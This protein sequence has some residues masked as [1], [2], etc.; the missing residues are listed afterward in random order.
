MVAAAW[1]RQ[2]MP[3]YGQRHKGL[4]RTS[5]AVASNDARW[6]RWVGA[7]SRPKGAS[8]LRLRHTIAGRRCTSHRSKGALAG[9]QAR[10]ESQHR[11]ELPYRATLVAIAPGR[12]MLRCHKLPAA[13]LSTEPQAREGPPPFRGRTALGADDLAKGDA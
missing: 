10:R 9:T 11:D 6:A 3:F 4:A 7:G 1:S 13:R 8:S 2:E 5:L 12:T